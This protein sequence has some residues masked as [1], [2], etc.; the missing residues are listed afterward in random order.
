MFGFLILANLHITLTKRIIPAPSLSATSSYIAKRSRQ[1][2]FCIT[3]AGRCP[4]TDL[5]SDDQL[6]MRGTTLMRKRTQHFS[7]DLWATLLRSQRKQTEHM[8]HLQPGCCWCKSNIGNQ[9]LVAGR[10][11][12]D[13]WDADFGDCPGSSIQH[14]TLEWEHAL[15]PDPLAFSDA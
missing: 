14:E 12:P 10:Q 1:M 9:E 2:S 15:S 4:T 5:F 6:L 11:V 3:C 13:M 7:F 8:W